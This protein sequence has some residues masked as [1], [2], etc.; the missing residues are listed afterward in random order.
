M[1]LAQWIRAQAASL[2]IAF[3]VGLTSSAL[4]TTAAA[5]TVGSIGGNVN[6]T[7]GQ[8]YKQVGSDVM[9][10]AG[11]INITAKKVDIIDRKSVV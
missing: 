5:S 3:T 4:P 8:T 1:P 11:D 6:I 9:A 7:A 10:P 2:F